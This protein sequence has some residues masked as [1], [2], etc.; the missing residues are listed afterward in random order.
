MK[1][2]FYHDSP[3]IRYSHHFYSVTLGRAIWERYLSVFD[4]M[5]VSTR[6]VESDVKGPVLSDHDLVA[7]RPIT[8]Y[9]GFSSLFRNFFKILKQISG[10]LDEVD[11]AIIRLP[12]VIGWISYVVAKFKKKPILVEMVGCPW[13]SYRF[14]SRAGRLIA[15]FAVLATRI[16]VTFAPFVIYV[17]QE[18]LQG[19]YPT[20]GQGFGISDVNV[21]TDLD[22]LEH[23]IFRVNELLSSREKGLLKEYKVVIGSIGKVDVA[24][25]GH[26]TAI[27]VVAKL[28]ELGY[29]VQYEIAGAGDQRSLIDFAT[30]LGI[31]EHIRLLGSIP[32]EEVHKWLD[33]IDIYVQPSYQ[34]GLPRSVVEALA[35]GLP[36]SL[37]SV[38]GQPELVDRK[39]LFSPG[40]VNA[41]VNIIESLLNGDLESVARR[42][43]AKSTEYDRVLLQGKRKIVLAEF[44]NYVEARIKS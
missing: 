38:G 20:R 35:H 41:M 13:D 31:E 32:S 29:E 39:Y 33:T 18:F 27:E 10:S 1:L 28:I 6:V 11:C 30:E 7:F 3:M 25:K 4:S 2:G 17:T 42:N 44:R 23:R 22:R 21:S 43:F 9:V 5:V 34:E 37:S 8:Q 40:D 14:Y 26:R 19:R 16:T 15:P 24:Y 36:V 12:S